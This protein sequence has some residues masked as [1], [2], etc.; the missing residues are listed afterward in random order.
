MHRK[1]VTV[2]L[3]LQQEIKKTNINYDA[4]INQLINFI[5]QL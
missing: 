5:N 4:F 2:T 3:M 1:V